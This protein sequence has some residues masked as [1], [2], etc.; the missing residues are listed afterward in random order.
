M[1]DELKDENGLLWCE[2]KG[3]IET[4]LE[5]LPEEALEVINNT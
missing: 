5:A 3:C 4:Y 2:V 1:W